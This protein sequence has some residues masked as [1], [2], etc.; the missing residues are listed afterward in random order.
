LADAPWLLP[1]D[2]LRLKIEPLYGAG[3]GLLS[4]EPANSGHAGSLV[5]SEADV[6]ELVPALL[7]C[8]VYEPPAA[9]A[10]GE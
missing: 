3:P 4:M 7:I 10:T 5:P 2:W 8:R 6:N 9:L 1:C